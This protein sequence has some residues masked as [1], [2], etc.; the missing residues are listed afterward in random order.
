MSSFDYFAGLESI[1][2]SQKKYYLH[3]YLSNV[4]KTSRQKKNDAT[5]KA[6]N[7]GK[8]AVPENVKQWIEKVM[9]ECV[10]YCK[11]TKR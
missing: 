3:R 1:V 9:Q 10:W 2:N 8:I 4:Q 6:D 5:Y 11:V 7:I